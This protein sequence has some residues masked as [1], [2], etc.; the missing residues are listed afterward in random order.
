ME[1]TT[2]KELLA[3]HGL[4]WYQLYRR[5]Q[6]TISKSMAFDWVI[7][8]HQPSR[9]SAVHIA[10]ALGLPA[11]HVLDV[12]QTRDRHE[13]HPKA[14]LFCVSCHRRLY[15]KIKANQPHYEVAQA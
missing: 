5:S 4:T 13:H 14:P 15:G 11:Q 1:K 12:L 2:V 7:G 3:R 8:K 6:G 9:K 10:H